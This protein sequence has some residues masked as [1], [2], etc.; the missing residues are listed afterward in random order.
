[1]KKVIPFFISQA[2]TLFGSQIVA[3]A[4]VCIFGAYKGLI[5]Y[6]FCPKTIGDR[7][8]IYEIAMRT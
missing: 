3:F 7:S 5:T 2:I 1:M 4:I 8:S 6:I